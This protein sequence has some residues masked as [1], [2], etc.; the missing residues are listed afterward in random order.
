[1]NFVEQ[2]DTKDAAFCEKGAPRFESVVAICVHT[3]PFQKT[4]RTLYTNTLALQNAI[5][6]K[7]KHIWPGKKNE[8]KHCLNKY[9]LTYI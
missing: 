4:E 3:S 6:L 7:G 1:M 2:A 5:L 9:N 8:I